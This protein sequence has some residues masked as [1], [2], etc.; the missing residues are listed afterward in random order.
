MQTETGTNTKNVNPNPY[1]H[2]RWTPRAESAVEPA[3]RLIARPTVERLE[4]ARLLE[5]FWGVPEPRLP[6]EASERI[7]GLI[8]FA[9]AAP[10]PA[11]VAEVQPEIAAA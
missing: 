1:P 9:L 7:D 10:A 2:G 6:A 11:P 4:G 5:C 3:P 8:R